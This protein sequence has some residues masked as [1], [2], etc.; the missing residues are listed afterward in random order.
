MPENLSDL[1]VAERAKMFLFKGGPAVGKSPAA[2][3]F[4]GPIYFFDFDRRISSVKKMFPHRND[5]Y[6]DVFTFFKEYAKTFDSLLDNCPYKTVVI[7]TMTNFIELTVDYFIRLR[8]GSTSLESV[9]SEEIVKGSRNKAVK[10]KGEVK[11]LSIDDYSAETRAVS[12]MLINL[13]YLAEERRTNIIVIA[14]IVTT[15]TTN[16]KT[17]SQTIE[18][19]LLTYGKKAAGKIPTLFDEIYHF[20]TVSPIIVGDPLQYLIC[21]EN[22]GDDYARTSFHMPATIDWTNKNLYKEI[23]QYFSVVKDSPMEEVFNERRELKE[24]NITVGELAPTDE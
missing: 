23:S 5:I 1:N 18:K 4:P 19:F 21:T 12:E 6:Y 24:T 10:S 17:G 9:G 7:D 8:G 11:L 16:I 3:S 15:S 22:V 14:H 13:K 20:T 2:A